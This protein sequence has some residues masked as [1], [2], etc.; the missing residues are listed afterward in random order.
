MLQVSWIVYMMYLKAV[1]LKR[2]GAML[3]LIVIAMG[4]PTFTNIWLSKWTD[5]PT[6]T[7][8]TVSNDV[9]ESMMT[10]YLAVFSV[11]GVVGGKTSGIY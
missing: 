11:S 8:A 7:N 1:G 9:K 4:A 2:V 3:V 10:M 6:F 5:D